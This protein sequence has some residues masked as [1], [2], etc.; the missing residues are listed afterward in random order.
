MALKIG[1]V[2]TTIQWVCMAVHS[3]ITPLNIANMLLKECH[4]QTIPSNYSPHKRSR[5]KIFGM[6]YVEDGRL[7]KQ[8]R[9]NG[10]AIDITKPLV[11]AIK[12]K[13]I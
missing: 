5:P 12:I 4:M 3:H 7:I 10:I 2:L 8:H 13:N 6:S 9:N 1:N 11:M